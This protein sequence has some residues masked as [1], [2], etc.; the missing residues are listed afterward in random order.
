MYFLETNFRNDG[1]AFCV[2]ESGVNLPVMWVKACLNED[3]HK[4]LNKPKH[5][6][7]MPEFQ[8]FKLVLQRR[9]T[10]GRWLKDLHRTDAFLEYT[11]DDKRPFFQFII[12]KLKH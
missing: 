3:Y 1:N 11:K 2:T 6:I 4:E 9:L 7:V 8:D 12:D 5:I 10:L